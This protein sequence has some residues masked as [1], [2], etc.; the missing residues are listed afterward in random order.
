MQD[1][2]PFSQRVKLNCQRAKP[3]NLVADEERTNYRPHKKWDISL[4]R[5]AT[6]SGE[7]RERDDEEEK[8]P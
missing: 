2:I 7:G 8:A 1:N 3:R 5:C 6:R 4:K